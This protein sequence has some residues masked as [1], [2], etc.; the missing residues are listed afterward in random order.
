MSG[1]V[2]RSTMS[3]LAALVAATGSCT[4]VGRDIAGDR[5]EVIS[6][7]AEL[8]VAASATDLAAAWPTTGESMPASARELLRGELTE[9]NAMKIAL[10]NNR[11]LRARLEAVGISRAELVQSG[12]L[13]NPV[14][15]GVAKFFSG[16]TEIEIGLSQSFL[17][18]LYRPLRRAMAGAELAAAKA[19][20][21]STVVGVAFD[22]RRAFNE[23]RAANQLV[24]LRREALDAALASQELMG[25]L[26]DAGNV[27][28]P[29]RT[30]E[31]LAA[32]RARLDLRAAEAAVLE[33]REPLNILLGLFGDDVQWTVTSTIPETTLAT[34]NLE[35]IETRAIR[36]SLDLEQNRARA[37]AAAQQAGL[38]SWEGWL[39]GATLGVVAKKE[40][41]SSEFGPGP[42][43]SV[44]LPLFDQGQ[45]RNAAANAA[46]R[47]LLHRHVALAVEIRATAR[48]LRE[49]LIAQ[50]DRATYL[51][52][53]LTPLEQRL[54][55][56]TIRDYNAMQVGAF[57]VI[58]AKQRHLAAQSEAITVLRDAW[59]ARLDLEE[60]LAGRLNTTR[61]ASFGHEAGAGRKGTPM[62]SRGH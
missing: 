23:L 61:S 2:S 32:A 21:V 19:E 59:R 58:V 60:L 17:D 53:V 43:L 33:A 29:L 51:R 27:I 28:D 50:T 5:D 42:E 39:G 56:E 31:D 30:G 45:A 8:T 36:A 47:S 38:A 37:D 24:Q 16:G 6:R 3:C 7:A 15:S 26:H 11:D 35:Q 1:F 34:M 40:A 41:D 54:V 10:L 25:I 48:Q 14:L 44:A 9:D 18:L 57:D 52:E 46:L 49:R 55:R 62:P 20:A 13:T 4:S 22:V 12:L